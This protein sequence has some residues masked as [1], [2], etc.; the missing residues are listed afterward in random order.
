MEFGIQGTKKIRDLCARGGLH[1]PHI[2][3]VLMGR[4]RIDVP[5]AV[6]L[7][8]ALNT[9]PEFWLA[10]QFS[11]DCYDARDAMLAPR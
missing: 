2:I 9:T 5:D 3:D 4:S 8:V 6:G 11:S 7:A 10:L 1:E